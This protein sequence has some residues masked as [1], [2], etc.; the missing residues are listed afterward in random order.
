MI[1]YLMMSVALAGTPTND[2]ISRL[3]HVEPFSVSEPA[4]F[5]W[6]ADALTF[7]SGTLFVVAV[8]KAQAKVRQV[9][10]PVLY[11]GTTPAARL[12]PGYIDGHIVAYVPGTVDLSKTPIY[13][14][15]STLPE[16][17]NPAVEGAQALTTSN[18]EPFAADVVT[19]VTHPKRGLN[20]QKDIQLR[21]ADL[22]DRFAP[23]DADFA[24]G[25][26]A[27]QQR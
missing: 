9:G 12:N 4:L 7:T 22:I 8:D 6:N 2:G 19:S 24:R 23:G 1:S 11:V 26:R 21:A 20:N 14:G 16:R 5:A 13:W 15:P 10:G 18:A 27:G 17:V 25:Y 3:A